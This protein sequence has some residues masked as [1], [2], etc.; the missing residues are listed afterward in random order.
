MASCLP[1]SVQNDWVTVNDA[2]D[3]DFT[4]GM[5]LEAWVY[6]TTSGG[7]SWRNLLIKERAGGEVYNLYA[8]ADTNAPIIYVVPSAP[9]NQPLD[10]RGSASLPLNTWSH[11][12][13]TYDGATLRLYI[14]GTQRATRAVTGPILTSANP[15]KLGGNAVWGEF[16][17]GRLDEVRVYDRALTQ[18]QIQGDMNTAL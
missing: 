1:F 3:L 16:F 18:A 10:A 15:L 17:A 6:P 13:A 11:L 9:P 8:N 2:S 12:A 4:T 14:N 7:G 5:T